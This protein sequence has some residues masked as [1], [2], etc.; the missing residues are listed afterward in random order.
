MARFNF[1]PT[2]NLSV[3]LDCPRC[4]WLQLNKGIKRPRGLFPSLPLGMDLAIKKYFDKYRIKGE[5]PPEIYGKIKGKLLDDLNKLE[6]WRSWRATDLRYE[7]KDLDVCLSGAL[8]D[9]LVD[10]EYFV[11]LDYK[12]KGTEVKENPA[13][14]YQNQLDCY[15]LMLKSSGYKIR[16]EAVIIYYSPKEV[17]E[18]GVVK[19][20]VSFFKIKTNPESAKSVIRE[21]IDILLGPLPSR[22][23]ECEYCNLVELNV[24]IKQ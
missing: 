11:P 19:F 12:T 22:N 5:L 17:S 16:N 6:R 8:D 4:F 9:C 2:G 21:A 13:V 7:D 23:S 24:K 14:Y 10:G 1:S 20:N 15:C 3:F 18:D